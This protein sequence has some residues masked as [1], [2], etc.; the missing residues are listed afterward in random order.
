M[1]GG[2]YAN[3]DVAVTDGVATVTIRRP[4]VLNAIDADT[5]DDLQGAFDALDGRD[6]VRSVVVTGAGDDAFSSG[7]DVGEYE[8]DQPRAFHEERARRSF[9]IGR[10]ARALHAPT[11]A[12]VRGY[13]IGA[14]LI[15]AMYCDLRVAD[16]SA[17]FGLPTTAIGQIPGGGATY[18]LVELVGEANAKEL[19]LTGALADA[20]R[21]EGMGL[22]NRVVDPDALDDA[23][24]ALTDD[25][26]A[27]GRNAVA[28][29]KASINEAADA[30][31]REAAF[32]SETERWWAQ[33]EARSAAASS[34][35][36]ATGS[37]P[38]AVP[39]R[40]T[41]LAFASR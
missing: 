31:N 35:S 4:D 36:S 15:L 3:L 24:A 32:E 22:V 7:A 41:R 9:E 6:D 33:F 16:E 37:R 10:A 19:V 34:R 2:P 11:I 30:T 1:V 28:A 21:A 14:G 13:C 12:R 23:V 20:E 5:L 26:A 38:A 27:G 17:Q 25:V 39:Y 40:S 29:A 18:R 8:G